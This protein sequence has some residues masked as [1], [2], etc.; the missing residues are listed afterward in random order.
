VVSGLETHVVIGLGNPGADYENTPH[1][2][3]FQVVHALAIRWKAVF[4]PGK[5]AFYWT[6]V[7][8]P[9]KTAL[10]KPTTYMNRSGRATLEVLDKLKLPVDRLLVVCDD[11]HL[12]LGK[13]RLRQKGG[14]GGHRGLE[15][16]IYHLETE[17]F[18]RLRLGIGGG[19]DPEKWVERVLTPFP[20]DFAPKIKE[21]IDTAV[22]AVEHWIN[23][24]I[25][26]A[27]N[28][29]NAAS[30][31]AQEWQSIKQKPDSQDKKSSE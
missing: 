9:F 7:A 17:E 20:G 23:H 15:S 10:V 30:V 19:D 11:L 25:E 3:G 4:R 27:M 14:D 21:M 29:F 1:N 5:G 16:I 26:S 22:L 28:R 2:V 31:I 8:P 24:G 12:P 13:I 6:S 18:A